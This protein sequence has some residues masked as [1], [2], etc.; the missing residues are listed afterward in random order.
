MKLQQKQCTQ[1]TGTGD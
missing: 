1:Y